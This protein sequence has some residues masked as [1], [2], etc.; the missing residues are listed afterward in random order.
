MPKVKGIPQVRFILSQRKD[1]A[2]LSYV[3][4]YLHY[5][6]GRLRYS[7]GIKIAPQNWDFQAQRA[8][9]GAKHRPDAADINT[10]LGEMRRLSLAIWNDHNKGGIDPADF[11]LELSK[12]LGYIPS[13][14]DPAKIPTLFEFIARFIEEKQAQPKGTWAI[15]QTCCFAL[16]DF[17][18]E[19]RAPLT[20]DAI[21]AAFFPDFKRWLYARRNISISYAAKL[22]ST[23]RT[24]MREAQRRG[25]HSNQAYQFFSIKK[26]RT[27]KLTLSFEELEALYALDLSGNPRLEKVRDLFLI[28][29]YTGL[30]FSDFSRIRP[31]HVE[32]VGSSKILSITAQKTGQ[33]ISV[34]LLPIPAA[35]LEKYGYHAPEI[36]NQKLND[37]LKELGQL[38]G[39]TDKMIFTNTA[40]GVRREEVLPKWEKLT[41]HCARRSF[42]TNFYRSGLIPIGELRQITGH[43]TETQFLEYVGIAAKENAV[44]VAGRLERAADLEATT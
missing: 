2:A 28:G 31:E 24:L 18:S 14:A 23:L 19:R 38:A 35:L 41:S 1:P 25:Y 6:R 13:E 33:E 27:N 26:V 29:A 10:H 37:Y 17:A 21:N 22:I 7:T 39:L 9:E 40:G 20:Y 30:R 11:A 16:Q 44:R 4:L 42:A 5:R 15:Y 3:G 43:A 36:S 34:P 32:R 8:I 12:R